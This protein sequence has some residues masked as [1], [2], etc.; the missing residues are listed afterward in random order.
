MVERRGEVGDGPRALARA[1]PA[2]GGEEPRRPRRILY[3]ITSSDT[4]GAESVLAELVPRLDRR[5]FAPYVCTLRAAGR[6]AQGLAAGGV[7]VLGLGMADRPRGGELLPGAL[8]LARWID[9]LEIDLVQSFL[10]RANTLAPLAGRLAAR[11]PARVA[12]ESSLAPPG[13]PLTLLSARLARRLAD[14]VVAVSAAVR[15]ELV[16]RFGARPERVVV[17]PNG[18]DLE[19]YRAGSGR[20]QARRDLGLPEGAFV[21]GAAGRM[22][23]VKAFDRLLAAV[24]TLRRDGLPVHLALAGDG[25]QRRRLEEQA[26]RLGIASSVSFLGVRGDMATFFAAVDA[27]VLPSLREGSPRALLEAMAAGRPVVASAVGGVPEIVEDARS[28]LLVP[29][30]SSDDLAAALAR[31]AADPALAL[32]LGAAARQRVED[33]FSLD[34]MVHAYQRLYA[35]LLSA[36]RGAGVPC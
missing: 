3:V 21:A 31:L 5:R 14:R 12:V 33:H 10:Y 25:P 28:G 11:R 2:G 7:P 9:A 6:V 18:V 29:P 35:S 34:A 17:I 26:R 13:A 27:F 15:D 4:G 16:A 32:G 36:R 22:L 1:G 30:G 24:P 8:A 19:R 23:P 20:Q